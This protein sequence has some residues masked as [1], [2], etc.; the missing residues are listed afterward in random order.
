MPDEVNVLDAGFKISELHEA[1]LNR[2][3][4]RMPSNC[5][6]RRNELPEYKGRGAHPK[7]G[8]IDPSFSQ[9]T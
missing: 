8:E 1:S 9:E 4:V 5:T 7:F 6:A 3:V 2:Y